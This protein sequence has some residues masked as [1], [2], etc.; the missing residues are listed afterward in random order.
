M[1]PLQAGSGLATKFSTIGEVKTLRTNEAF[2]IGDSEYF[3]FI[4]SGQIELF[5]VQTME[6]EPVGPRTHFA[7]FNPGSVMLGMDFSLYGQSSGFLATSSDSTLIYKI[8]RDKLRVLAR[9]REYTLAV[10]E[11]I[12]GWL[13]TLSSSVARDV[14]PRP[15]PDETLTGGKET[16]LLRG[17]VARARKGVVW[18]QVMKGEAL[19]LGMEAVSVS[20]D[21]ASILPIST[22]TWIE[23]YDECVLHSFSTPLIIT[24]ATF[25]RGIELFHEVLCQCEF[26][27]KKLRMV[28]EFN[29]I[30]LRESFGQRS[31]EIA[32][33]EIASVLDESGGKNGAGALDDDL[34]DQTFS[35]CKLIGEASGFRVVAP[36]D[37]RRLKQRLPAIAKASRFRFR[38]VALRDNWWETDHG[39][40]LA[41]REQGLAPVAIL[42]DKAT[43]YEL[44]DTETN[45]RVP[46]DAAVASTLCP[47]AV[48]LYTPFPEHK[49]GA[50]D[51]L[52]FGIRESKLDMWTILGMGILLGLLGMVTPYFSGQIFDSIIPAADRVQL[53]QF[54]VGLLA[55]AFGTFAF[56]LVRAIS[57]LRMAG[58]MDYLVQ[59]G[60]WD[61]L[62]SLPSNFFRDYAAGDLAD[63]ALGVDQ[64]RQAVS[65][66]G[67]Q[68]IV[69]SISAVIMIVF[70]FSYNTQMAFVAIGLVL[71][72]VIFPTVLNLLQVKHQRKLFYIRGSISGL[73]LQLINGVNKLRVSGAEDRAFREWARKFS[74]QKRIAFKAGKLANAAHVF[75][76]IFPVLC[77]AII[78]GTYAWFRDLAARNGGTFKMSTGEFIAFNTTFTLILSSFLS[79]AAAS[80]ELMIIVPLFE[81]LVPIIEAPPEIDEAK[82]HPGEL[83]GEIEVSHLTFRYSADGPPILRDVSLH[84]R[85]GE[86][87]A[88]VGGSG[89]GKSTLL[90]LLLGF[91]KPESGAILY[92]NQDLYS[93]DLR[94]VRQQTGVVLQSS[95]LMPTDIY[96]NIIGSHQ[97]SLNDAWEAARMSGLD[98]DIKNMPMGMNTVVSEGGG[99]FSGGQRQRLM[100]AR[101]LVN[102]PRIIF[103]DEATSALDNE[104]QRTVTDSLDAMQSTRIV[105]AHRL[106]TIINADR[107]FVLM[108]GEMVQSGSYAELMN[109]PGPFAELAKRQLA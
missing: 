75:N 63:R 56:E 27:N 41:Y 20:G 72:S 57:V 47:F 13:Q 33:R 79:L 73:V 85:P 45:Q 10:G 78:F 2:L 81:R 108:N 67:T 26:I 23:A 107:I 43:N 68:A 44:V 7:T 58:K 55:A 3:W 104:T 62:L 103:F 87:V 102:K 99:T 86:F 19:Y 48:S 35:V 95:K 32:L 16:K 97:L 50:W 109:Q 91:E 83:T 4:A 53:F 9:D 88:L 54:A 92:D 29:R 61:R 22:D 96:R 14:R 89:S 52:K 101:A 74:D 24:Q 17:N 25:W 36:P 12:N 30:R 93:L 39:P 42:K 11:L 84:I 34:G 60:V 70:L 38:S 1:P 106:S 80:L 18:I 31:K 64:I 90:R 21:G 59:A 49:L 100:V 105:I 69:G 8:S 28:D 66:A 65:Q 76:Q 37:L 15:K 5:V 46:I 40:L 77:S 6:D 94:E 82:A 71:L 98:R 51:L